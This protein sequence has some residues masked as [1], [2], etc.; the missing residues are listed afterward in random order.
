MAS[1]QQKTNSE[2]Q[3]TVES[4]YAQAVKQ[5]NAGN[6]AAAE[7]LCNAILQAVPNHIDAIN[8]LGVIAQRVGRHDLAVQ[9]FQQALNIDQNRAVLHYNFGI[10]LQELGRIDEAMHAVRNAMQK[11]P[12]NRQLAEYYSQL[13]QMQTNPAQNFPP[14]VAAQRYLDMGVEFHQAGKLAEAIECYS[15]SLDLQPEN[16]AALNNMGGALQACGRLDEAVIYLQKATTVDPGF[17][18]AHYNLGNVYTQQDRLDAAVASYKQAIAVVPGHLDAL[19]NLGKTL[20]QQGKYSKAIKFLK[21]AVELHPGFAKALNNIGSIMK[22]QGKLDKAAKYYQKAIDQ[23]PRYALAYSNL[24]IVQNRQGDLDAAIKNHKQAVAIQPNFPEALNNLGSAL[25]A[26]G[27]MDEGIAYYIRAIELTPDYVEALNNLGG[28][29]LAQGEFCQAGEYLQEAIRLQPDH[30]LA[31][32]N[33]GSAL[34]EQE[35]LEAAVEYYQKALAIRPDYATALSNLGNIQ[36]EQGKLDAAI[37]NYQKA[38]AIR[39]DFPEAISTLLFISQY[40]T[41]QNLQ[42][43]YENHKRL[44]Q[45][46]TD[47][48]QSP[49]FA[50]GNDRDPE[51]RLRI[52]LVSPDLGQHPVGY[53]MLGFL[54]HRPFAELDITCYSERAADDL[55]AKLQSVADDWVDISTLNN[56]ALAQRINA[57]GIDILIDLAGHTA[58]NRLQMFAMQPAPIQISWAG[59]VG[60]TGL[61]AMDWLIADHHYINADEEQFYTEKI[62]RMPDSWVCYTPPEYAPEVQSQPKNRQEEGFLL[63]NFGNQAKINAQMMEIWA[64]ILQKMPQAKLLLKYK[65]MDYPTNAERIRSYF[66]GAGIDK[67]RILIEGFSQHRE[68]LDRYNSVDLALDTLPYSGGLTTLEALWMGVPVVTSVGGTFAGRHSASI[69]RTVGLDELVT[70][71]PDK[72]VELVVELASDPKRLALLKIGLRNRLKNSPLCDYEKF[73]SNLSGELRKVWKQWCGND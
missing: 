69:L 43:L 6:N 29:L 11:E 18:D 19:N 15:K 66:T 40:Q 27:K 49:G 38:L 34:K 28:A 67:E 41:S 20:G 37:T 72:Y 65:A 13:S 10:S 68:L 16:S 26:Q 44:A 31:L 23:Q 61:A 53:F 7:Q 39:P 62:I 21:Q 46:L 52:G 2:P 5:F 33:Y 12:D 17:V 54:S 22:E 35:Q 30:A 24:G 63:G 58:R 32:C 71:D 50:H 48:T 73:A 64:A 60:T 4:A 8:T 9:Q 55:T 56:T 36:K 25:T 47:L 1:G 70:P 3:L 57:D 42:E 45:E 51:R 59:Y 14:E